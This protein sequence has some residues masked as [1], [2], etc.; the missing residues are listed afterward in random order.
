MV[1]YD[2]KVVDLVRR[3]ERY[4]RENEYNHPESKNYEKRHLRLKRGE[5]KIAEPGG[6]GI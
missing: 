5:N 1:L 2:K 3:K 4:V 6:Y